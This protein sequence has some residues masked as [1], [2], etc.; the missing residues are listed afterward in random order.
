ME[1]LGSGLHADSPHILKTKNQPVFFHQVPHPP[2]KCAIFVPTTAVELHV[3][4]G[5]GPSIHCA[6]KD[7]DN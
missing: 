3:S 6:V 4:N 5:K 1:D 2:L 7:P